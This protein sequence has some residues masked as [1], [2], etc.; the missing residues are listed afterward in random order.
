MRSTSP[1][2]ARAHAELVPTQNMH[3]CR[4]H[5]CI[6]SPLHFES[7]AF[8]FALP[9]AYFLKD[10]FTKRYSWNYNRNDL[11]HRPDHQ[12]FNMGDF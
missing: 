1:Y 12:I 8:P 6:L 11:P 5:L 7:L 10:P 2:K 3:L 9:T 4:L